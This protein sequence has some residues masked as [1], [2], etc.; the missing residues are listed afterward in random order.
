MAPTSLT[1][2]WLSEIR[3]FAPDLS[4]AVLNGT[5]QQ[6]AEMIRH[7]AKHGDVDV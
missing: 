6:R 3:R 4:A 2:N 7:I 1:Y 5:A